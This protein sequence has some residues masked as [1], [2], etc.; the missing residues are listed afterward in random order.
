[1]IWSTLGEKSSAYISE[2]SFPGCHYLATVQCFKSY[3]DE[4]PYT[5]LCKITSGERDPAWTEDSNIWRRRGI[6]GMWIDLIEL[7][8]LSFTWVQVWNFCLCNTPNKHLKTICQCAPIL[9]ASFQRTLTH[10]KQSSH[11]LLKVNQ[12][13][14]NAQNLDC[15]RKHI[16]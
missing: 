15:L 13:I 5:A 4:A 9:S 16:K 2:S 14:K 10:E 8:H 3:S 12:W 1:M 6:W 11:N 7:W